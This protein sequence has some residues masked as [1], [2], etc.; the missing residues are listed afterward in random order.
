[1]LKELGNHLNKK[2][3]NCVH[4]V[5]CNQNIKFS[6]KFNLHSHAFTYV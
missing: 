5:Q 4:D 1:M 6:Y 2:N 3:K